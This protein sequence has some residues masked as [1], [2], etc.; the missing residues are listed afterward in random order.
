MA[1]SPITMSISPAE[2]FLSAKCRS[3]ICMVFGYFVS[4]PDKSKN[5]TETPFPPPKKENFPGIKNLA[6]CTNPV[7][8]SLTFLSAHGQHEASFA[9]GAC[10]QKKRVAF[11]VSAGIEMGFT[12][13][14]SEMNSSVRAIGSLQHT[15]NIGA[16]K[17]NARATS[18]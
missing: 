11:S 17:D 3:S 10:R 4:N 8:I 2:C 5:I 13:G 6:A 9:F 15:P 7:F 18:D 14:N 12:T 16:K 1:A